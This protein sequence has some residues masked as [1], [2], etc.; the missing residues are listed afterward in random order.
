MPHD[1]PKVE[2]QR[3]REA[4]SEEGVGQEVQS[5]GVVRRCGT[6]GVVAEPVP[7]DLESSLPI[8]TVSEDEN[9][10]TRVQLQCP[11]HHHQQWQWREREE[12]EEETQESGGL[13]HSSDPAS[14]A[15]HQMVK[16]SSAAVT[17]ETRSRSAESVICQLHPRS[18]I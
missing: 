11:V 15:A 9:E 6:C 16:M 1:Q 18:K 5:G 8:A 3:T 7:R 14:P 4:C 13:A 17:M 2:S 10:Q 12:E